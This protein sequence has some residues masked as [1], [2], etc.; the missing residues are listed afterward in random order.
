MLRPSSENI[1]LFEKPK[2]IWQRVAKKPIFN[3]EPN[4]MVILDSMSFLI[5][6]SNEY[7]LKYILCCLNNKIIE[8][9][10]RLIGHQYGNTGFLVSNQYVEKLPIYLATHEQQ[11][12]FIAKA[13]QMLELNRILQDEIISFKN[14][15][16]YTFKIAKLSQKLDKYYKLSFDNFLIELKKKKVDVKSRENYQT[17]KLEFEKSIAIINPLLQQIKETD[18]EIDQMVYELYGLTNEEIKT[19]EDSL[20]ST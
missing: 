4:G 3:Y 19:I 11:K 17:L 16:I 14:W 20:K 5:L 10:L 9:Y 7:D 2:L 1:K 15:F 12:L 18:S 13:N 6:E 8:W